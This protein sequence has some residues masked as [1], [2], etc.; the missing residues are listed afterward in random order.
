MLSNNPL[1]TIGGHSKSHK[2]FS[3]LSM[4]E[5]KKDIKYSINTINKKLNTRIKHYSYPEGLKNT[6][7]NREVRI[8]KNNG[9]VICPSAEF[10]LNDHHS[11]LFHLNRIFCSE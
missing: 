10:G 11:N 6:Y 8:L 2:I 4:T 9:I 5:L 1:F 7:S 3:S